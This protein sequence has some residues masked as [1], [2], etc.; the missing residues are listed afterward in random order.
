VGFFLQDSEF[1]DG[2]FYEGQHVKATQKDLN[3]LVKKDNPK[4]RWHKKG[5]VEYICKIEKVRKAFA[6]YKIN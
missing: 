1:Y 4:Y 6:A 2:I 3:R 5:N